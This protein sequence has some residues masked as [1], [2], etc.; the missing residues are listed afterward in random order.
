MGTYWQPATA[1]CIS[2]TQVTASKTTVVVPIT[3]AGTGTPK[4]MGFGQ[5]CKVTPAMTVEQDCSGAAGARCGATPNGEVYAWIMP[6]IPECDGT[7]QPTSQ[8]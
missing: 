5:Q 7:G 1:V 3:E 6:A 4:K 8:W 2:S